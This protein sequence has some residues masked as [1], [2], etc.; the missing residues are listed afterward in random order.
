MMC[1][2]APEFLFEQGFHLGGCSGTVTRVSP[3]DSQS[4]WNLLGLQNNSVFSGEHLCMCKLL[5]LAGFHLDY[6][7]L[8]SSVD[9]RFFL[10][11]QPSLDTNKIGNL[12]SYRMLT[13]F[14][15]LNGSSE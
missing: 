9:S 7:V 5:C 14:S 4:S 8:C 10:C 2:N 12:I 11:I 3:A 6:S 1:F 15:A 13:S